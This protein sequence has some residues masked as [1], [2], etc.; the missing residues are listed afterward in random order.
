ML[1]FLKLVMEFRQFHSDSFSENIIESDIEPQK[2]LEHINSGLQE[3]SIGTDNRNSVKKIVETLLKMTTVKD[4][5]GYTHNTCPCCIRKMNSNEV[6]S[7]VDRMK[8]FMNPQVSELTRHLE[9]QAQ[10][11]LLKKS[12][13]ERWR[14]YLLD[15]DTLSKWQSSRA[16]EKEIDELDISI[17]R[18]QEEYRVKNAAVT[19][20]QKI[21]SRV[22]TD[23]SNIESVALEAARL[24]DEGT[25]LF[26][27]IGEAKSKRDRLS[28][29]APSVGNR[30][31][32]DVETSVTTLQEQKESCFKSMQRLQK[33]LSS[34]QSQIQY[35]NRRVTEEEQKAREKEDKYN[36]E[37]EISEKKVSLNEQIE[38]LG[39]QERLKTKLI[40]PLRHKIM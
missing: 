27:K 35:L 12:K 17:K 25:R 10:E 21:K 40:G 3:C 5:A 30:T 1:K 15:D 2:L 24:R 19:D 23:I 26:D 11:N 37:R 36:Q 7:Y 39:E 20:S 9:A 14:R 4:S 33:E 28:A 29:I 38:Q 31:I 16:I 13:Y 8:S 6:N 18:Q 34:L 32:N 22:R